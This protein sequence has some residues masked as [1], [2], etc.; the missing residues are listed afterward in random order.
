MAQKRQKAKDL[1]TL[2]DPELQEQLKALRQE[3]WQDRL[4]ITSGALPQVHRPAAHRRQIARIHTVL[5]ERQR[6]TTG[7]AARPAPERPAAPGRG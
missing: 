5:R 1:R 2:P 6:S 3:L 7:T 4:K